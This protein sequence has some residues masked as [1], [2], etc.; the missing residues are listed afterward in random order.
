MLT[1]IAIPECS[2]RGSGY[3]KNLRRK[4]GF[5]SPRH[6]K[7]PGPHSELRASLSRCAGEGLAADGAA[8]TAGPNL[9]QP[10]TRRCFTSE[11]TTPGS[12]SVLV[13]PS[14]SGAFSAILRRMR[15]MILPERVLGDRK[16]GVWGKSVLGRVDTGG[17]GVND[18]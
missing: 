7:K 10:G 13:S 8:L 5:L 4:A 11:S 18:T 15:R 17:C 16:S 1:Q 9:P 3:L 6:F 2:C 12:A 14:W